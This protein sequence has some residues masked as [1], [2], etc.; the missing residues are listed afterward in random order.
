VI[1]PVLYQELLLGGRKRRLHLLRGLC[2]AVLWLQLVYVY[3]GALAEPPPFAHL[4]IPAAV[5]LVV[6]SRAH[7]ELLAW[8]QFLLI[9]LVTPAFVAGEVTDA[10]ARGTLGHLLTTDLRSWEI[11]LGKLLA[12]GLTLAALLSMTLPLLCFSATLGDLPLGP[13][14]AQ[15]AGMA[16]LIFLLGCVALLASVWCRNTSDA[17]LTVYGAVLVF[18]LGARG[19]RALFDQL[20][21]TASTAESTRLFAGL[22]ETVSDILRLFNPHFLLEPAWDVGGSAESWRRLLTL[23]LA[24]GGAGGLC[25]AVAAWRLRPAYARQLE[26]AG[27][28]RGAV[29]GPRPAPGEDAV[30]WKELHVEGVAPLASL[31]R[32]PRWLALGLVSAGTVIG[33]GLLYLG[34]GPPRGV[35]EKYLFQLEVG[36]LL[37]GVTTLVVGVRCAT[38]ITRERE[39]GTWE[40]LLLTTLPTR[41]IIDAK[42]RGILWAA[43]PYLLAYAIPALV[44]VALRGLYGLTDGLLV[45]VWAGGAYLMMCWV[46]ACGL[47]CSARAKSSW[48]SL[49]ATFG[50]GYYVGF[51]FGFG[52]PA[53]LGLSLVL[54]QELPPDFFTY[55]GGWGLVCCCGPV[56]ASL[57]LLW[58]SHGMVKTNLEDAEKAI[59]EKER[60][61]AVPEGMVRGRFGGPRNP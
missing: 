50:L 53:L 28:R 45:V 34:D 14:L 51:F 27:K 57:G 19:L 16:L 38:A 33:M 60:T 11:L 29:S 40:G 37:M 31:R 42:F 1:G 35:M 24:W 22:S 43:T 32:V 2:G 52:P 54:P 9:L 41:S 47:A 30:F 6:A 12:Q 10:K 46:A 59:L 23:T 61:W 26:S 44:V 21:L 48:R 15:V 49:L 56:A 39:Q 58:L 17:I 18:F 20:A 4:Q 3:T 5:R 8:E 25:L 55:N 7:V 13:V 36:F